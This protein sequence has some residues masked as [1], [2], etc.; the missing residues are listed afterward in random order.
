MEASGF[1]AIDS[2]AQEIPDSAGR[3]AGD[4]IASDETKDWCSYSN[5]IAMFSRV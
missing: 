3:S 5:S 4:F 1:A 2:M